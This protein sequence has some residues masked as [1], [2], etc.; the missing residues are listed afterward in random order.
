MPSHGGSSS[1]Y[2]ELTPFQQTHAEGG[3]DGLQRFWTA[4]SNLT[5][6]GVT[7]LDLRVWIGWILSRQED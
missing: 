1:S 2:T 5:V 3:I 7:Q 4:P 6:P